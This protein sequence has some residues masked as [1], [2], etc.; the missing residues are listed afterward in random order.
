MCVR[1]YTSEE[2]YCLVPV[3]KRGG[4]FLVETDSRP[5]L[6]KPAH[7]NLAPEIKRLWHFSLVKLPQIQT[8]QHHAHRRG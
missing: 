5:P 2:C 7:N 1:K 4:V 6:E 8:H 3:V